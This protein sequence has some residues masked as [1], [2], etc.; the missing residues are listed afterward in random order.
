MP[1]LIQTVAEDGLANLLGAGGAHGTLVFV[2]AQAPLLERQ[3]AIFQQPAHLAL[4]VL[5]QRLIVDAMDTPG[6]HGIEV[7]HEL[8]VVAV[9]A[10]DVGQVIT[11]MLPAGEMLFEYRESASERMPADIDDPGIDR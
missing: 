7:R 1:P 2:E 4:G 11:E 3:A 5:H 8:D 9:I 10:A 6:Q